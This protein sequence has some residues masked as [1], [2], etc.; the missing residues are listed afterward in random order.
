MESPRTPTAVWRPHTLYYTAAVFFKTI[1]KV[2]EVFDVV[3]KEGAFT[4]KAL[5]FSVDFI[6]SI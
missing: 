1:F 3:L 6:I 5:S 2:C 4:Q